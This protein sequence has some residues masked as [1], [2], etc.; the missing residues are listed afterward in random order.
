MPEDD[1]YPQNPLVP[2]GLENYD[3][4]FHPTRRPGAWTGV[5]NVDSGARV[6]EGSGGKGHG[7]GVGDGEGRGSGKNEGVGEGN[8][9]ATDSSTDSNHKPSSI[10]SS[11]LKGEVWLDPDNPGPTVTYEFEPE[12]FTPAASAVVDFA[13]PP[14]H[15]LRHGPMPSAVHVT[16]SGSAASGVDHSTGNVKEEEEEGFEDEEEVEYEDEEDE[17]N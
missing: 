2:K 6:G 14:G 9:G 8:G 17:D 16:G 13:Y 10:S 15:P 1:R 3:V 7:G 11:F 4:T 12:V 5:R